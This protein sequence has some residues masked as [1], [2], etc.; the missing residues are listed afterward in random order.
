MQGFIL[1]VGHQ[2][3]LWIDD[4]IERK[5]LVTN[6]TNSWFLQVTKQ[7]VQFQEKLQHKLFCKRFQSSI[8]I[9]V[10]F[11]FYSED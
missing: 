1:N 2:Y 8:L 3:I 9:S 4:K 11:E 10:L 7:R 5:K 6:N